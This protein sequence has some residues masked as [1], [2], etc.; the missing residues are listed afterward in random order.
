[1]IALLFAYFWTNLALHKSVMLGIMKGKAGDTL[2]SSR[3]ISQVTFLKFSG[4][5][6]SYKIPFTAAQ[7]LSAT[8]TFEE[9]NAKFKEDCKC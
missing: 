2:Y 6:E 8:K 3:R 9:K 7:N 1:M 5:C 4:D